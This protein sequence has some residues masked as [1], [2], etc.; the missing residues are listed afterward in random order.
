V[1]LFGLLAFLDEQRLRK[2][3]FLLVSISVGAMFGDVFIHLLPEAYA[4][5]QNPLSTSLG[6]LAG[7]ML[8]FLFEKVLW[9]RHHHTTH[10]GECVQPFGHVNVLADSLHNFVDG[11]LI[12]TAYMVSIPAGVGTTLAVMLHE[13]PQEIGDVAVLLHAG[14]SR[15]RAI[16]VNMISASLAI[17]GAVIALVLGQTMTGLPEAVLPVTAGGFVY[18][19]GCDLVPE[20]HKERELD[21]SFLQLLG[22]VTGV[23]A[24]VLLTGLG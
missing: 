4:R 6:V 10:E 7:L 24:M 9:W 2:W 23:G 14:F 13:I 18:I 11:F 19:A 1:S 20:L 16:M 12:A 3:V 22:L 8:F 15:T 17:L 21:R 5:S